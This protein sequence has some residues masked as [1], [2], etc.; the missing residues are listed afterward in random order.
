MTTPTQVVIFGATG[1]LSKKSLLPALASLCAAGKLDAELRII[2]VA[3]RPL[4]ELA[5]RKQVAALLPAP[6]RREA[7]LQRLHYQPLDV[8]AEGELTRLQ[9]R[10]E[11]LAGGAPV[12]RL[13]YLALSPDLFAPV[14]V[15]LGEQGL[16]RA[17]PGHAWPWRRVVVEKPFGFDLAS[18]E[19]LN[20][21]LTAYL[22]EEQI[23]R[24][25]H[26]LGK[27]TVQN[28]LGLR[29]HNAIFE[30]LWNRHHVELVQI[31]VA[32]DAGIGQRGPSYDRMGAMRDVVQNHMLQLLALVA[33]EPPA[34]LDAEEIRNHKVSVLDSL[35]VTTHDEVTSLSVR[36]R[37][38]G[39][40]DESGV[41]KDSNSETFVAL[42]TRLDNWRWSGVPF[43]LRHGKRLAMRTTH[44][45]VHFRRP[46]LQLFNRPLGMGEDELRRRLTDGSLCQIRPNTL[47]IIIQPH[48]CIGLSFGVK[49][50]GSSMQMEPAALSYDYREH[51][52]SEIAPPYERLLQDALAG[53]ATLFLRADEVAASWRF[54]DPYTRVWQEIGEAPQEYAAGSW[55]PAGEHLFFGCE[56][57]WRHA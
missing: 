7:F 44:I 55:G 46:P 50:P 8:H 25:D 12:A 38:A 17:E 29:F 9:Q 42:R 19:R 35:P 30:P 51:F 32:E 16:L 54:V 34:T 13:Y 4:N 33:M 48:A 14:I 1:D 57:T 11:S 31:T 28:L 5:F 21:Q 27:E 40:L 18:A 36:G 3:R 56:G 39:Y 23:F 43:F 41:A 6:L 15:G 49:R 26:Y 22:R 37:Y 2:G 53:D 20:N 47:T 45:Q 24:I 10:L 52:G